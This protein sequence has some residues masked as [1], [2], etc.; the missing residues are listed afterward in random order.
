MSEELP[1]NPSE[2]QTGVY[3]YA[4]LI[5]SNGDGLIDMIS[6]VDP[7]GRGVALAVDTDG[8]GMLN[9]IH[10]FQ[11]VTGDG[12]LDGDDV[13]LIRQEAIKLFERAVLEEGQLELYVEEGGYG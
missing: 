5:D 9:N 3:I 10:V 7:D 12:K 4:N 13:R 8:T 6:F 2:E 1:E 11:D